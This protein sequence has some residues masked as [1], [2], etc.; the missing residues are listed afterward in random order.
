MKI[1]ENNFKLPLLYFNLTFAIMFCVLSTVGFTYSNVLLYSLFAIFLFRQFNHDHIEVMD[2]AKYIVALVFINMIV[3]F[4]LIITFYTLRLQEEYILMSYI[5]IF[6][7][8]ILAS[9]VYK[10]ILK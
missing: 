8:M 10:K 4:I 9:F 5:S 3:Q 2:V 1:I 7:E 6:I